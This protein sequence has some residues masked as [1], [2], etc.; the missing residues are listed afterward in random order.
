MRS[1]TL[2]IVTAIVLTA[3]G[4]P[5]QVPAAVSGTSTTVVPA[6]TTVP[7][8]ET[9]AAANTT[10]VEP[11]AD[12]NATTTTEPAPAPTTTAQEST[13]VT[14]VTVPPSERIG[15]PIAAAVPSWFVADTTVPASLESAARK[16]LA[17][18]LDVSEAEVVSLGAMA[19]QW[20]SSA[21]GCPEKGM[22]YLQVIIDGYLMYFQVGQSTYSVH[23]DTSGNFVVCSLPG[24]P[25]IVAFK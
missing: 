18:D 24:E 12:A 3:C 10:A 25:Q 20:P 13:T 8:A 15:E 21:L 16:R 11:A 7:T 9:T 23:A 1:I 22:V 4:A 6:A 5:G 2:V 19:V 14:T 17:A